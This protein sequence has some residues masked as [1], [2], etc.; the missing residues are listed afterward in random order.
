MNGNNLRGRFQR[1]GVNGR[2]EVKPFAVS[3]KGLDSDLDHREV[4]G[5]QQWE[6]LIGYM[7]LKGVLKLDNPEQ[8]IERISRLF[9][10]QMYSSGALDKQ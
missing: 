7:Q 2:I 8:L 3:V 5:L 9:V 6:Q 4:F 10:K 1:N